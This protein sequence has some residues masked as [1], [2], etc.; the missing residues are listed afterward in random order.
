MVPL[1]QRASYVTPSIAL[2]P[3][4]NQAA[5]AFKIKS[6][7]NS[8]NIILKE[9]FRF[10]L[11]GNPG[12]GKS[13]FTHKLC[14]DLANQYPSR[15]FAGR[16]GLTPIYVILRDYG[17]EKKAHNCSILDFIKIKANEDYQVEAPIGTFEY[18]LL[19]GRAMVIFDGLDEL[20]ETVHRQDVRNAVESFCTAY[21]SVPVL[22]TSREIGY[23][24]APLDE[25]RIRCISLSPI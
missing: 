11:L 16:Q 10:V 8:Y 24:Q 17:A 23:E 21:P 15:F 2:T 1:F 25:E 22:V 6:Q 12:G 19:N 9:T 13:T 4:E 5:E 3:G 14:Y 7:A 20:L 18:L